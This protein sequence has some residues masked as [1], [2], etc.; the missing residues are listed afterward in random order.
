MRHLIDYNKFEKTNEGWKEFAIG[1]AL[2]LSPMTTK[3][4][5]WVQRAANANLHFWEKCRL[6]AK[7]DRPAYMSGGAREKSYKNEYDRISDMKDMDKDEKKSLKANCPDGVELKDWA[8]LTHESKRV[9]AILG[10]VYY[11]K[12]V[13]DKG[14]LIDPE[15]IKDEAEKQSMEYGIKYLDPW[16]VY[17]K[18]IFPKARKVTAQDLLK[19]YQSLPGGLE[20]FR[21]LLN[22]GY[23]SEK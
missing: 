14:I 16:F 4:Q 2:A 23:K 7:P 8:A 6:A 10:E 19:Y 1:A 22:S 11:D 9:S 18:P 21:N 3:S 17:Y 13:D 15:T 12:F 20:A 5:E